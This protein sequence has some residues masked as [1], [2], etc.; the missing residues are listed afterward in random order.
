MQAF[1]TSK[2]RSVSATMCAVIG[3]AWVAAGCGNSSSRLRRRLAPRAHDRRLPAL[4][5]LDIFRRPRAAR[6]LPRRRKGRERRR[7]SARAQAAV[8]LDRLEGRPRRCRPHRR[9]DARLDLEP[10]RRH[11]PCPDGARRR[12]AHHAVQDPDVL[13]PPAA[14]STTTAPTRTTSVSTRR[15]RSPASPWRTGRT[16]ATARTTPPRSPTTPARRRLCPPC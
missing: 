16:R 8:H 12:P 6:W 14:P 9:Q 5:R 1:S 15:T 3:L 2:R 10:R 4:Q 7:R 13:R 11:R